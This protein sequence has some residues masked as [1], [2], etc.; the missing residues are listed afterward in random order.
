MSSITHVSWRITLCELRCSRVVT[1]S[2]RLVTGRVRV[3]F[4]GLSK[5][6]TAIIKSLTGV[7]GSFGAFDHV[8]SEAFSKVRRCE[9]VRHG[10][11]RLDG[12]RF[13]PGAVG[14]VS[15]AGS[16]RCSR[17]GFRAEQALLR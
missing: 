11:T 15:S 13:D 6:F 14:G 1:G 12:C 9:E 4:L 2:V 10:D 7:I 3:S 17:L 8:R 16:R 5:R